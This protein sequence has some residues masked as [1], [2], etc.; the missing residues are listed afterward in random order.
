[1]IVNVKV[2]E[3]LPSKNPICWMAPPDIHVHD[4]E[5]GAIHAWLDS[6]FSVKR[7]TEH[8]VTIVT[9]LDFEVSW[10]STCRY[11][12]VLNMQFLR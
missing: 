6:P 10:Y 11:I 8:K 2:T 12:E 4:Q 1:M 3:G 5:M 9:C 7:D